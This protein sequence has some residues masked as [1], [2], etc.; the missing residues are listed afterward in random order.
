MYGTIA[1]VVVPTGVITLAN[2][3][4][5]IRVLWQKRNQQE[6]WRR[7]KKLTIQ[8][9]S[10]SVLY[11]VF[12]FPLTINGLIYTYTSSPLLGDLQWKYF[13]FLPSVLAMII[14]FVLVPHLSDF[15]RIVFKWRGA[16]VTPEINNI[17]RLPNVQT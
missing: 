1:D 7:Q 15:E 8:L 4:L 14:P 10:I 3:A 2:V 16:T 17:R 5:T 11:I 6:A 9:L 13:L 12:W